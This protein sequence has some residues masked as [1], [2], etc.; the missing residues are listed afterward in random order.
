MIRLPYK[1]EHGVSNRPQVELRNDA[2]RHPVSIAVTSTGGWSFAARDPGAP[3]EDGKGTAFASLAVSAATPIGVTWFASSTC[4]FRPAFAARQSSIVRT[5]KR[6][7]H[8]R[9]SS[10]RSKTADQFRLI[11]AVNRLIVWRDGM[12]PKETTWSSA[13]RERPSETSRMP[14]ATR[15]ND[16][17]CER[18]PASWKIA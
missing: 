13:C 7:V 10:A 9:E 17:R 3:F 1:T 11:K 16:T 2:M 8:S 14:V 12:M 15:A 18:T 4:R 5:S 6:S